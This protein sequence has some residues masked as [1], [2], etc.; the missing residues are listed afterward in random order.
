[1]SAAGEDDQLAL[2]LADIFAWDVDFNTEL[3]KGDSF[4]VAVEK[5]SLDGKLQPL[6]A[7]SCPPSSCAATACCGPCASRAPHGPGYYVPDGTP[8]RQGL[9]ALAAASSRA[10]ARGF[11]HARLHPD[12]ERHA[13]P[14]GVDYA[15]PIGTPVHARPRTAS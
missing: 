6:R 12:P 4:R 1:M 11:T 14:L 13:A 2:D 8:L 9:P 15:A 5:L 10:S 3:Q 7:A